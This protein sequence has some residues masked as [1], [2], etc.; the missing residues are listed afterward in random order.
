[1]GSLKEICSSDT[2]YYCANIGDGFHIVSIFLLLFSSILFAGLHFIV[3]NV[4]N[5]DFETCLEPMNSIIELF[6]Q[7]DI[8]KVRK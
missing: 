2:Q 8:K 6:A 3:M 5:R 7:R 4:W 1:M